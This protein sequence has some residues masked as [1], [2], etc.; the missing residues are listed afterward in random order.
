MITFEQLFGIQKEKIK[1]TCV[2]TPFL[3]DELVQSFDL[4]EFF[5]G[6]PFSCGQSEDISLIHTQIGAP[7]VGDAVLYL[8]DT[9][10]ENLIFL[11]ACSAVK[12]SDLHLGM[13]VIPG[14]VANCESFTSL[15]TRQI[16]H[17]PLITGDQTLFGKIFELENSLTKVTCASFGSFKLE[18]TYGEFLQQNNIQV[19]DM[20][21]CAFYHAARHIGRK[22]AALLYVSEIMGEKHAFEPLTPP[23]QSLVQISRHKCARI[24]R[25]L[26]INL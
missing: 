19:V 5:R 17:T 6:S 15:L 3:S 11:G 14:P 4:K 9:P 12:P 18:E 25:Q 13:I 23:Q 16:N 7:F 22:G 1:K 10:C 8:S 26:A 20:E 24:I 2:L 21:V